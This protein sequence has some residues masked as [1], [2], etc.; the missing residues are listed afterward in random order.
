MIA[1]DCRSDWKRCDDRLVVHAGLDQFQGHLPAH[2][3]SLFRQP[4]LSHAAFAQLANQMKALRKYL[5]SFQGT[6]R[7]DAR[8]TPRSSFRPVAEDCRKPEGMS[9]LGR[10]QGFNFFAQAMDR[11][12]KPRRGRR[13]ARPG[14]SS[15]AFS[16]TSRIC[17]QRSG[18][19]A[20]VALLIWRCSQS[21]AVAQCR[22]TVVGERFS[23]P[24]SFID[25]KAAEESQLD[26]AGSVA[27]RAWPTRSVRRP[28]RSCPRSASC[29]ARRRRARAGSLHPAFAALR[30]RAYSTRIC[31]ISCAQMAM[32]CSR[33][34]NPPVPCFS[35][36]R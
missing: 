34:S 7:A 28:E 13:S 36:R 3:Q 35:S 19:I 17:C 6:G 32:K 1:S 23:A 4:D 22:F 16:S 12:S 25:G 8:P 2:R 26:N 21:R 31:R 33:F 18:V 15:S 14:A 20:S 27:D 29:P 9:A 11:R 10:E 30:L 5:S 24:R